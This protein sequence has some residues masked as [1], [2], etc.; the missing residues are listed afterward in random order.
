VTKLYVENGV[1]KRIVEAINL[2]TE[3]HGC[4]ATIQHEVH[5]QMQLPQQG[6]EW[7]IEDATKQGFVIVTEG[8]DIFRSD[9]ER[10]TVLRTGA[11]IIGFARANY[12]GWEMLGGFSFHWDAIA[13]QLESPGPWLKV[14]KGSTA[15][16]L[17]NR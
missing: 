7:W 14:Y 4:E 5:P 13:A 1:G 11:R 12:T 3:K 16:V 8:L 10:A 15:P 6:D 9:S 2:F 17:V